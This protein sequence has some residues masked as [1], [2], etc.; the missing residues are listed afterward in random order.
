MT[1][2]WWPMFSLMDDIYSVLAM[3]LRLSC[4]NPSTCSGKLVKIFFL[5][6][7]ILIIIIQSDH[8]FAHDIA[9]QLSWHE[10][11]CELV[12]IPRLKIRNWTLFSVQNNV[13]K[14]DFTNKISN[15]FITHFKW[16]L[17]VKEAD[18][19]N[20]IQFVLTN[21]LQWCHNECNGISNHQHLDCLL[22]RLFRCISKKASKLCVTGLCEGNSPVTGGFPAQRA[23][24]AENVSIS[25]H[26]N[27]H[28]VSLSG[29]HKQTYICTYVNPRVILIHV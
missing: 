26:H 8:N 13:T 11:N 9:T 14:I 23:I 5:L 21:S 17:A 20:N 27:V 7:V 29:S 22:N 3:E 1:Y 19:L 16:N 6:N 15:V 10:Q 18:M 25:W 24:N 28:K 4:I 2:S 12:I